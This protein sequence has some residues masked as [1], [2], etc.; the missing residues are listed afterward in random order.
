MANAARKERKRLG[1]KI[2]K[3]AKVGTPP[4][5]RAIPVVQDRAGRSAGIVITHPSNRAVTRIKRRFG[6][7]FGDKDAA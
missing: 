7:V 3:A 1:I 6:H 5:D 2:V 4:E